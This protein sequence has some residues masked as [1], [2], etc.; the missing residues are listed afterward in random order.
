MTVTSTCFNSRPND[1]PTGMIFSPPWR[2]YVLTVP[3][4]VGAVEL[5]KTEAAEARLIALE[6]VPAQRPAAPARPPGAQGEPIIAGI[7]DNGIS[8]S[9]TLQAYE[10]EP[11]LAFYRQM[12][13]MGFT[14]FLSQI[15]A[16]SASWSEVARQ[17]RFTPFG[18]Q[19]YANWDE[20]SEYM[21]GTVEGLQADIDRIRQ[22]GMRMVASFRI[23]NEWMAPWAREHWRTADGIPDAAS[24]FS[25]EHPEFWLTYKDGSPCGAGLDFSYPQVRDYRRALIAEWCEKFQRFDGVCI[26]LHRHP[27]MVSYPEHLVREFQ[28][29]TGIDVRAVEPL[30][31]DTVMPEWLEFRVR[32]FTEYM[33]TVRSLLRE[34]YGREVALSARVGNTWTRAML[35]GANLK[36][37]IDERLVDQL[38]LQHRPPANPVEAD[39]REIIEAA[40]AAGIEVVHLLGSNLGVDFPGDDLT[41]VR[42]RIDTWRGWGSDGFGF[43]EAERIVRDG[44]WLRDMPDVIRSWQRGR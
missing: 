35:E 41:P 22:A 44:R 31:Q 1:E 8:I 14:H 16:G 6:F 10:P 2:T 20:P 9:E 40:R 39:S 36:Q 3:A 12:R 37:W 34:R 23:N 33:R 5:S 18:H 25:V 32:P 11:I 24:A 28:A 42:P 21:L 7:V 27:P 15:F 26:D 19:P 4:G 38:I 13:D 30:V 17:H 29:S 43:Y